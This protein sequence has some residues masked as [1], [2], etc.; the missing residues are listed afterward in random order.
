MSAA[1]NTS[2][3]VDESLASA[4]KKRPCPVC[5]A[6]DDSH[7]FAE[8]SYDM[9]SLDQFA[10]ASRKMP[11]YMHY[12]LVECPSCDLVYA[13][14]APSKDA[15]GDAYEEAAFDSGVEAH[16]AAATYARALDEFLPKL[17]SRK[18]ALD[19][20]TGDG[21]FL[22]ELLRRDFEDVRGVE[23][24]TAPIAAALP[25]IQPLIQKGLFEPSKFKPE[26]LSLLTCFQTLE[27]V[28]DPGELCRAAFE[29]LRPGG[30]V[31]F[32][33]HNRRAML[34]RALG[35][36]SPIFDIEHLQLFSPDS[37]KAL[38]TRAG[39]QDVHLRVLWNRY[40]LAYWLKLVP[41]P[42]GLKTRLLGMIQDTPLGRMPLAAN[43]GNMGVFA[44]KPL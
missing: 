10:F 35:S 16:F 26:S 24:S 34:N 15:V 32:V 6:N 44:F 1:L 40:P 11:E 4:L 39:F 31:F 33:A 29:I 17:P 36:K 5:H 22:E 37:V 3:P 42:R 9:A 21:A 19:V 7:V 28:H 13:N 18:G 25:N 20:G 12:R 23:P 8:A 14:P 43:V 41:A 2:P 38:V 30:C 27:H